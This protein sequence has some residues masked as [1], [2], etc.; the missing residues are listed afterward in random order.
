MNFHST[1]KCRLINMT[2][3]GGKSRRYDIM[4]GDEY[5]GCVR[6][7]PVLREWIIRLPHYVGASY[8]FMSKVWTCLLDEL[9]D[10]KVQPQPR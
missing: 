1:C 8:G 9:T 7:C 6:F 4:S 10:I 2:E 3:I 5:A